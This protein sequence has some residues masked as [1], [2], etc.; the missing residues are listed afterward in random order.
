MARDGNGSADQQR[1]LGIAIGV[2]TTMLYAILPALVA[3]FI[4]ILLT[5]YA[6]VK[7][8]GSAPER[9]N[10]VV[11]VVGVVGVV[12]G[13]LV[14]IAVA[15]GLVGRGMTPRRRRGLEGAT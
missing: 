1:G 15:V 10:P 14:L 9:A 3:S 4:W 6:L 5:V 12:T 11:V 2:V 8:I 13:L 7:W